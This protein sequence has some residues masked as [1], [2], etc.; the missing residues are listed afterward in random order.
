MLEDIAYVFVSEQS[1]YHLVRFHADGRVSSGPVAGAARPVVEGF[2]F[3]DNE[4]SS[5][6]ALDTAWESFGQDLVER[7][8]PLR[9]LDVRGMIGSG[10]RQ[11]WSVDYSVGGT[12]HTVWLDAATGAVFEIKDEPC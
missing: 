12:D 6:D 1:S 10:G 8:G 7:C 3:E 9:W 4:V 2:E 11:V 5:V